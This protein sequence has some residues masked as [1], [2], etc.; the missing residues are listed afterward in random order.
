MADGVDL[1]LYAEELDPDFNTG[2]VS[3]LESHVV[4]YLNLCK[5]ICRTNLVV[6]V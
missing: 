5:H 2:T 1:D 4:E 6:M 3:L